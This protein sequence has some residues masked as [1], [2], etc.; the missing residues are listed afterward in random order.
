M[1]VGVSSVSPASLAHEVVVMVMSK[2][3]PAG[4]VNVQLSDEKDPPPMLQRLVVVTI[5]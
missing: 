2:V 5:G 1:V 3:S 4:S